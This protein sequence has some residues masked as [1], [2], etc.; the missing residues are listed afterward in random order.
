MFSIIIGLYRINCTK[1]I[2]IYNCN[3]CLFSYS[4]HPLT[5]HLS[6]QILIYASIHQSIHP[7]INLSNHP[8]IH[9]T[10]QIYSDF[11]PFV[12]ILYFIVHTRFSSTQS[13]SQ[14]KC[15]TNHSYILQTLQ[16][17]KFYPIYHLS[18]Q[19]CHLSSISPP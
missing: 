12:L 14:D 18:V 7:F 3:V 1:L 10:H 13:Y 19:V 15:Q 11:N 6:I 2:V 4:L 5:F 17:T 8:S 16:T 9:F